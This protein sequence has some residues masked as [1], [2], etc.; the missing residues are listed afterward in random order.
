MARA[1][2]VLPAALL[3]CLALAG[4]ADAVRKT[5]GVYELKNKKGDFSIK[6]TNWGATL[7]SVIVPDSKGMHGFL[8]FQESFCVMLYCDCI[9][10]VYMLM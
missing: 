6:V 4:R 1:A 3:L 7:M 8:S 10:L 9:T 2:L 5:V